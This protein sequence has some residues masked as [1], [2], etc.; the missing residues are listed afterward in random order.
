MAFQDIREGMTV[1]DA[2]GNKLGKVVEVRG[3][4]FIIEK[5]LIFKDDYQ[6]R[7]DRILEIRDD[8]IIYARADQSGIESSAASL[9][10]SDDTLPDGSAA[11]AAR[12]DTADT[13]SAAAEGEVRV[14]LAEEELEVQKQARESGGVRVT[15]DVVTEQKQVTVPVTREQ[16]N[17]ERVPADETSAPAAAAF[18]KSEVSVPVMEEEVEVTKRPVVREEVRVRKEQVQEQR[19]VAAEVR[20]EEANVEDLSEERRTRTSDTEPAYRAPA[21]DD[22]DIKR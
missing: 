15:K 16:V 8:E 4:V 13:R 22:D 3:D 19:A 11:A 14:P 5:G 6:A 10:R 1:R 20:H 18:T 2:D 12:F 17:V 7:L 9:G 21:R